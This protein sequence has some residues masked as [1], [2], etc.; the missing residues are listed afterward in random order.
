M[1]NNRTEIQVIIISGKGGT[2]KTTL[3]AA[4]TRLAEN[5]VIS[6]CD[7]DAAD[8]H[9]LLKPLINREHPFSGGKK[10]KIILNFC[11]GCGI[12]QDHCQFNAI[13]NFVVDLIKC[14]G[15]GFCEKLCPEDAISF[16]EVINGECFEGHTPND[17]LIWAK[18]NPGEGNSGK[19]VTFV[20]KIAERIL[21]ENG[22]RWYFVDGPPGIG[23]P[24]NASITGAD[25]VLL[26]TEPTV[27]GIHDLQRISELVRRFDIPGGVVINKFDLNQ[28]NTRKIE[29]F[30]KNT[31]LPV[32]GKIPYD[33][34]VISSL[35][36]RK[37]ITEFPDSAASMAIVKIWD[38][39]I[40]IINPKV[41]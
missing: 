36:Q 40:R 39:L 24:V 28:E 4:L 17:P 21:I 10:A 1:K 3:T 38:Y 33:E 16:D 35:M 6:D 41:Q 7:V 25:Y 18:L 29:R 8:L 30:S 13:E 23:C 2:G 26:V 37:I 14:E 19:L 12:C 27:S 20:K 11:T 32:I 5:P 22:Y 15:C 34:M 9:L 31:P